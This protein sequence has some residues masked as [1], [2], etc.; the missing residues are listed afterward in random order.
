[1]YER[2]NQLARKAMLAANMEAQRFNH[3][4]LGPEHILL[5]LVRLTEFTDAAA[6]FAA[7]EVDPRKIRLEIEKL[8]QNGPDMVTMGKI[9][10]SPGSRQVMAKAIEESANRKHEYIG[11]VHILLGLTNCDKD[12]VVC[13]VLNPLGVNYASVEEALARR[14]LQESSAAAE[15]KAERFVDELNK[16]LK[17]TTLRANVPRE[18]GKLLLRYE[19][20]QRAESLRF[21]QG[22]TSAQCAM[23]AAVLLA[24]TNDKL[25]QQLIKTAAGHASAETLLPALGQQVPK[26]W[27]LQF[28]VAD[29][30]VSLIPYDE[31]GDTRPDLCSKGGLLGERIAAT[32][33]NM[34]KAAAEEN[35]T[36]EG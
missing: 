9:P 24:D 29:D 20:V 19:E 31:H 4:Y 11:T 25:A 5:G 27:E 22:L 10:Q 18:Y 6:V 17:T 16:S 34:Q 21:L 35:A 13:C 28:A 30:Y 2:F 36:D 23:A 15:Q 1:M 26:G 12:S 33:A 8:L 3:E 32:I 14:G 7:L